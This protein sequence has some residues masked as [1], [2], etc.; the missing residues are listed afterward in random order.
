MVGP[1]PDPHAGQHAARDRDA[2]TDTAVGGLGEG[3][4]AYRGVHVRV[5]GETGVGADPNVQQYKIGIEQTV[6]Y[7][8][9][10]K[11]S[12]PSTTVIATVVRTPEGWRLDAFR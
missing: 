10:R 12:L 2:E 1:Q 5:G 7:P 3:E 4:R 8:N 9:G 6:V 11:E